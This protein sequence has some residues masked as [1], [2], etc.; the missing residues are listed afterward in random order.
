MAKP[1]DAVASILAAFKTHSVVALGEG[2]HFSEQALAF[3]S[4]LIKDPRFS[5]TVND[6]VV[7]IGSAR[8]QDIMDRYVRGEE[9][10]M[11]QLRRA[12]HDTTQAG[13]GVDREYAGRLF[14][15]IREVN[16]SLPKR[17]QLRVLLGEPPIN[18][19]EIRVAEDYFKQM[20]AHG[21]RW[22]RDTYPAD[23]I[24][25]EVIAKR[26]RVLV[27]YGALHFTRKQLYFPF[28]DKAAAEKLFNEPPEDSIVVLLENKHKTKV[29]SIW[30]HSQGDL[31]S[32][33]PDIGSWQAPLLVHLRG[34]PWGLAPF[35]KFY[36]F[37]FMLSR[38]KEDGSF[39]SAKADPTRSPLMQEQFDAVLYLGPPNSFTVTKIAT[40]LCADP[41]YLEMRSKRMAMMMMPPPNA[42][43]N[44]QSGARTPDPMAILKRECARATGQ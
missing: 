33:Q 15:M 6:I 14:A 7:E 28:S 34:T 9:V 1:V 13:Q 40:E 31:S 5:R 10:D 30:S 24:Q 35:S 32:L 22:G 29:F 41:E 20:D 26:R 18:W 21:G 25:K 27:I 12:W 19:D 11:K 16:A 43:P 38:Q 37:N 3:Y 42:P 44:T 36:S 2:R 17:R 4:T 39:E 23:L 8:F